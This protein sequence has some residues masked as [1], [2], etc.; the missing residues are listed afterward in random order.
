MALLNLQQ[1]RPEPP[2]T[3]RSRPQPVTA[4]VKIVD[5]SVLSGSCQWP[6]DPFFRPTV[7]VMIDRKLCKVVPTRRAAV[8]GRNGVT[9]WRCGFDVDVRDVATGL[10]AVE[11]VCLETGCGLY[12]GANAAIGGGARA[13]LDVADLIAVAQQRTP[14]FDG[15]GFRSFL[16]FSISDQISL[17]YH[18]IL[19]RAPDSFGMSEYIR[20]MKSGSITILGIRDKFLRSDEFLEGRFKT[21]GAA[22]GGWIVWGGLNDIANEIL[23]SKAD[24]A[25][26]T[27]AE[28]AAWP[29]P[30][31]APAYLGR[32]ALGE[33]AEPDV[34]SGWVKDHGA[35]IAAFS[36]NLKSRTLGSAR[37]PASAGGTLDLGNLLEQMR[38]G[39]A[40]LKQKG[41]V[42]FKPGQAGTV[43]FGPYA[44]LE[45]GRYRLNVFLHAALAGASSAC[46]VFEI[47]YGDMLVAAR[48]VSESEFGLARHT[49]EFDV[50][51]TPAVAAP[52]FEFRI[53]SDGAVSGELM[54]INLE[55]TAK[56]E[57]PEGRWPSVENWLPI[58][59]LGDAGQR[60]KQGIRGKSGV[61]GHVFFGPYRSLFPGR[62]LLELCFSNLFDQK[63]AEALILF[64]VV[65]RSGKTLAT[66][67]LAVSKSCLKAEL[68]FEVEALGATPAAADVLEIRLHKRN[69]APLEV[70]TMNV[71]AMPS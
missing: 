45:P 62:Y 22:L 63:N 8:V 35:E 43:V 11:L 17:V 29:K 5:G 64:E 3:A 36:A 4:V 68:L 53:H 16:G 67:E 52:S 40:G 10:E 60:A 33:G 31:E 25:G 12:S 38:I 66:R 55:R 6:F 65:T 9:E 46:I 15:S 42:D 28:L 18:A 23:S 20:Q 37:R 21:A 61:M 1:L 13:P 71:S 34:L 54:A 56:P 26:Q 57:K 7:G 2:T 24:W 47:V 14:G 44:R 27:S 69:F 48:G 49:L 70:V 51:A 41:R 30:A 39:P 59:S 50:P 19:G 58:M 32:V